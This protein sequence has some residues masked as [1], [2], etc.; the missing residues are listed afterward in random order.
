[1]NKDETNFIITTGNVTLFS[2]L[3]FRF[4][5]DNI[6]LLLVRGLVISDSRVRLHTK[7][8]HIYRST[9]S[10]LSGYR[11]RI[12]SP[13]FKSQSRDCPEDSLGT[14]QVLLLEVA[15]VIKIRSHPLPFTGRPTQYSL[16]RPIIR[17]NTILATN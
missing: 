1:M 17:Q 4:I 13:R 16:N 15:K 6:Q 8:I 11:A 3:L 12:R 5:T 2:S 7:D 10:R 9:Q 14:S